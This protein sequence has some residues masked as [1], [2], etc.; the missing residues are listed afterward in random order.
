V[1]EMPDPSDQPVSRGDLALIS[2]QIAA[3]LVQVQLA[4]MHVHA[5]RT[6]ELGDALDE[7]GA[8]AKS[9]NECAN[10]MMSKAGPE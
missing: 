10:K 5:R 6:N 8:F 9:L 2:L 7:I 4:L 1:S 3:A